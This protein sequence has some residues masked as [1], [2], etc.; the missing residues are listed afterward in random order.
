M[1]LAEGQISRLQTFVDVESYKIQSGA[2]PIGL[3]RAQAPD[4]KLWQAH[5]TRKPEGQWDHG[6]LQCR[7][8]ASLGRAR[9]IPPAHR[10]K[11]ALLQR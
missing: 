2:S 1:Y 9:L 11:A 7:S 5:C 4:A 6:R 3:N 10:H 8:I